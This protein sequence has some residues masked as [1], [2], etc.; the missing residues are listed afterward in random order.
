MGFGLFLCVFSTISSDPK[1][2]N[3]G[4]LEKTALKTLQQIQVTPALGESAFDVI[5]NK[6]ETVSTLSDAFSCVSDL[7]SRYGYSHFLIAHPPDVACSMVAED[8]LLT[9]L[10]LYL[11][12][13]LV[14]LDLFDD[15]SI[16]EHMNDTSAPFSWSKTKGINPQP[17]ALQDGA[18]T[19]GSIELTGADA[20]IANEIEA[21]FAHC[22]QAPTRGQK[23]A[24]ITL[25]SDTSSEFNIEFELV[26]LFQKIFDQIETLA[27]TRVRDT[28][29]ELNKRE[30]EC[31]NWAAAGKTSG[32]IAVIVSLSEHTVNHYLNSCCKKLD[33]VNRTQAVA[34]AIRMRVIK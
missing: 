34:R 29:S 16:L 7:C 24:F 32:E 26:V 19:I 30:L 8:I 31:L 28:G 13:D 2:K 12:D 17:F 20:L 27:I 9:N 6:L 22:I 25:F 10:P 3:G 14:T 4:P 15:W 18:E 33:C 1:G 11:V 5:S 23:R 21:Q